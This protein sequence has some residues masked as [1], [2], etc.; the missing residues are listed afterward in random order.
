MSIV[1]QEAGSFISTEGKI[2]FSDKFA[3]YFYRDT[4]REGEEKI[5]DSFH[6]ISEEEY[7]NSK[8]H[9][10]REFLLFV[11]K[12]DLFERTYDL[13]TT[14]IKLPVECIEEFAEVF[15]Q[16]FMSAVEGL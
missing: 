16:L 5:K 11:G 2:Y 15:Q 4:V 8:L 9:D 3:L 10:G 7:N 12:A 14:N 6:F 13:A 1:L